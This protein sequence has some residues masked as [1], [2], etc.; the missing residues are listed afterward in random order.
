MITGVLYYMEIWKDIPGYEGYYQVSNLGRVKSLNRTVFIRENVKGVKRERIMKTP[1][2]SQGYP[3]VRLTKNG[4]PKPFKV[5][6]LVAIVFLNHTPCGMNKVVDH[7]DG[8]TKNNHLDNLRIVTQRENASKKHLK[9]TSQYTGVY[10]YKKIGKWHSQ[11]SKG[12]K[13]KHL[14]YFDCEIQAHKAYQKALSNINN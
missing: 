4:I 14:G 13:K 10:W 6:R 11:I 7:I 2:N 3:L 12:K 9:S 8:N 5:H 1:V